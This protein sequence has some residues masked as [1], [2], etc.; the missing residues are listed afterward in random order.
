M[1]GNARAVIVRAIDAL[2]GS[3]AEECR[4]KAES[5][6]GSGVERAAIFRQHGRA[7]SSNFA[8]SDSA[9]DQSL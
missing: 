6:W 4:R 1:I 7:S 8:V 3:K 2:A 9:V 5:E